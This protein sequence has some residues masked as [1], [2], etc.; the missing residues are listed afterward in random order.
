MG[1][2]LLPQAGVAI[3]LM[4]VVSDRYPPIGEIIS[5]VLLAAIIVYETLGPLVTRWAIT[6]AGDVR[7]MTSK[8]DEPDD[9]TSPDGAGV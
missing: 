8:F 4:R 6:A 9:S 7:D 1:L 3:G 2:A 5:A